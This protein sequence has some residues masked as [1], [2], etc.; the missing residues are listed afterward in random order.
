MEK[1][2]DRVIYFI[3]SFSPS[4]SQ[5]PPFLLPI[6]PSFPFLQKGGDLLWISISLGLSR[7]FNMRYIFKA[8]QV[9][10]SNSKAGNVV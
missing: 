9:W 10:K 6:D 8:T 1:K 3:L 4:H 7:F 5:S 2:I